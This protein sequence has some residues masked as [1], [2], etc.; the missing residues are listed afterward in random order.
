MAVPREV[1]TEPVAT[2]NGFNALATDDLSSAA[3][4]PPMANITDPP[5]ATALFTSLLQDIS[6]AAISTNAL[7]MRILDILRKGALAAATKFDDFK[8]IDGLLMTKLMAVESR[9]STTLTRL[10]DAKNTLDATVASIGSTSFKINKALD[11]LSSDTAR[12]TA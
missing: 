7:S 12:L 5:C 4:A 9:F 1:I 11:T 2:D 10:Q 8:N 3:S 6:A